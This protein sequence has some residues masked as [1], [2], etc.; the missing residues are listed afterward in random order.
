MARPVFTDNNV[1]TKGYT[2]NK[3]NKSPS[4]H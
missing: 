4:L 3:H 1:D 2:Q